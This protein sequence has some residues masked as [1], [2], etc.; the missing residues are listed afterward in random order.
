M[1]TYAFQDLRMHFKPEPL[2]V[3]SDRTRDVP[4]AGRG[5]LAGESPDGLT[6]IEGVPTDAE[7]RVLYRPAAGAVGDG[8]IVQRL[9]SAPDG[10]WTAWGLNP[11]LRYDVIA[12]KAGQN[13]VIMSDVAP[14]P[15]DTITLD[16][17]FTVDAGSGE[18][19][20]EVSIY[21][22]IPPYSVASVV[23]APP[24]LA[25]AISGHTLVKNGKVTEGGDYTWTVTIE[26]SNGAIGSK[27]FVTNGVV[28]SDPHINSVVSLLRFDGANASPVIVD[29]KGKTWVNESPSNIFISQVDPKFGQGCLLVNA[30][31]IRADGAGDWN[32][33]DGDF[34]I[35]FWMKP[36][37]ASF[38]NSPIAQW[39]GES[40]RGWVIYTFGDGL[41][42]S[43]STT[44]YN[45]VNVEATVEYSASEY[46]HIAVSCVSGVIRIFFNGALVGS[47]VRSYPL[48]DSDRPLHI[49]RVGDGSYQYSGRLD[50][51]RITK[52]VGRYS[53]NFT[54]PDK[55][56]PS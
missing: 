14:V 41:W 1:A 52:G 33:G 30:G 29:E 12:R 23:G 10:T 44:G 31:G 54:P 25:F 34:T 24:G 42:F 47:A 45:Q 55:S 48:F 53:A 28:A 20:G 6:T 35:E 2:K 21:G 19:V 51:V 4:Y 11:E 40:R 17:D 16:G 5:Y 49:G 56:F 3:A 50:D 39:D 27:T 8:V 9:S 37:S 32:F 7:L 18:I 15:Y 13:D 38:N 43:Y 22:G 26:S 36:A 46:Q